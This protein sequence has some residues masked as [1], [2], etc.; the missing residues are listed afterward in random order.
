VKL[1]K[2]Y[3]D[4]SVFGGIFDDEFAMPSREFFDLIQQ[5]RFKLIVSDI[6]IRE[7]SAAPSKVQLF[8]KEMMRYIH[9]VPMNE[10]ILHLRDA[11]VSAGIVGEKWADDAGHVAAAVVDGADL[12]VSWNFKHIVHFDKIPLYNAVSTLNGYHAID[13]RSP[14]EVI[15]YEE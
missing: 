8:Y 11:F 10:E 3:T 15:D 4:T 14:A 13:I 7:I 12:I 2:V 6:A 1:K 9:I 5:G